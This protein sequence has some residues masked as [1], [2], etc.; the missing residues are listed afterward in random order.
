MAETEMSYR[1]HDKQE[2]YTKEL[3]PKIDKLQTFL[4]QYKAACQ[5]DETLKQYG[6]ALEQRKEVEEN[7]KRLRHLLE[8][9]HRL[10]THR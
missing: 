9:C 8:S 2:Y 1:W 10:R 7:N 4:Q 3:G 5:Y 6:E